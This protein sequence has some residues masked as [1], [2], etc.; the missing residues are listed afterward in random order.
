MT[1]RS[2]LGAI[3]EGTWPSEPRASSTGYAQ[4]KIVAEHFVREARA[5]GIDA[6]VY[7]PAAIMGDSRTGACQTGD[8]LSRLMAS[9]VEV[10]AYPDVDHPL[11]LVPV[12][13]VGRAIVA[14][15]MRGE[16]RRTFHLTGASPTP[17]AH[18]GRWMTRFGYPLRPTSCSSFRAR[19]LAWRAGPV[20]GTRRRPSRRCS[21]RRSRRRPSRRARRERD[22]S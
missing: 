12:D 20:A 15:V 10:G 19:V 3:D 9:C 13:H 7:R 2:P 6:A 21:R 8:I 17:I 22:A 18:V 1:R 4:T 11:E 5:R 16:T 14:L